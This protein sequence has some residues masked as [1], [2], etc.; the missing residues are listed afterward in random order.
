MAMNRSLIRLLA[1]CI[2]IGHGVDLGAQTTAHRLYNEGNAQHSRSD[3]TS[4]LEKYDSSRTEA[5]KEGE[6]TLYFDAF[7]MLLDC[8]HK[9]LELR[10]LR[11]EVDS[12]NGHLNHF[13]DKISPALYQAKSDVT[14]IFSILIYKAY[15]DSDSALELI[16]SLIDSLDA[17]MHTEDSISITIKKVKLYLYISEIY[18]AQGNYDQ[19]LHYTNEAI[20]LSAS[21]PTTDGWL[22]EPHYI[23]VSNYVETRQIT[24]AIGELNLILSLLPE[25]KQ[26]RTERAIKAYVEI[27]RL[28]LKNGSLDSAEYYVNL[29]HAIDKTRSQYL[30]AGYL[31][32]EIYYAKGDLNRSK[33]VYLRIAKNLMDAG[34]EHGESYAKCNL[35][36]GKISLLQG[37][38]VDALNVFQSALQNFTDDYD[39]ADVLT[40]PSLNMLYP[41]LI[42]AEIIYNKSIALYELYKNTNETKYLLASWET[43]MLSVDFVDLLRKSYYNN[44]DKAILIEQSY[45]IFE[46]ALR[47][48]QHNLLMQ[49]NASWID[50]AFA[51]MERSKALNLMDAVLHENARQFAGIPELVLETESSLRLE[52]SGQKESIRL[53]KSKKN[54]SRVSLQKNLSQL[55][56]KQQ[57]YRRFLDTIESDHPGYYRLKYG[58]SE[59]AIADIQD[60]MTK[61][62]SVIEYFVGESEV[63]TILI[64]KDR[65]QLVVSHQ[66]G[67]VES[68]VDAYRFSIQAYIEGKGSGA[69]DSLYIRSAVALYNALVRPVLPLQKSVIV[70]QD[71]VLNYISFAGLLSEMPTQYF[72]F[73]TQPYMLW[74]HDISYCYS[75]SLFREL[76]QKQKTETEKSFVFAPIFNDQGAVQ[77]LVFNEE[78]ARDVARQTSAQILLGENCTVP[79]VRRQLANTS[80]YQVMHFATH[81]VADVANGTNS[82]LNFAGPPD[83]NRF[84]ARELYNYSLNTNL[85]FLSACETGSGQLRRGEGI[86]SIARAFFYAGTR[87]LVTALWSI[88]DER[89]KDMTADFYSELMRGR[90]IDRSVAN[91]QQDYLKSIPTSERY[92]AHP[93]Y[94]SA[95]LP[96]GS[97]APIVRRQN[98]LLLLSLAVLLVVSAIGY[99]FLRKNS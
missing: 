15:G 43:T 5:L 10:Q 33:G 98:L 59:I 86:I 20:L 46:H 31:A 2:L 75:M 90:R 94:W 13:R 84:Y 18:L 23:L 32:G 34:A 95:L 39:N 76:Q 22:L 70:V 78:E 37:L 35:E 80:D 49:D 4:A 89:A 30:E 77:Q 24:E 7:G 81:G 26:R 16:N 21:L 88:S 36:L 97:Q 38:H 12:M 55:Y 42:P 63:Y 56:E 85:V 57:T 50:T 11:F 87:S 67:E 25:I 91:A 73:R 9:K 53:L 17:I 61:N 51:L 83:S 69:I 92:L 62:E 19:T 68:L 58:S 6:Y 28:H 82:Y 29:I 74:A 8:L 3:F 14:R 93:A 65:K 71:G 1:T 40:N 41:G 54:Y 45:R 79:A 72:D 44:E 47:I 27:G 64:E 96:I 52:V 99:V 48:C 66:A 60:L